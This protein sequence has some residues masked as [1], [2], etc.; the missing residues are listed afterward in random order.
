MASHERSLCQ[1][2]EKSWLPT[3]LGHHIFTQKNHIYIYKEHTLD[4]LVL[5]DDGDDFVPPP[6]KRQTPLK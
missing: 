6:P 3:K 1:S 2:S 4:Y 5:S